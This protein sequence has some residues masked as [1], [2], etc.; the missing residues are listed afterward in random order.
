M[1][2]SL[3]TDGH[4]QQPVQ[5]PVAQV[6]QSGNKHLVMHM[7]QEYPLQMQDTRHMP[8]LNDNEALSQ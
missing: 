2:S 5:Q 8:S 7:K 1:D 6:I 3:Q 4:H